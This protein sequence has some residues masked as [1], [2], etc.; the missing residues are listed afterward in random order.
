MRI[1]T[2]WKRIVAIVGLVAASLLALPAA[3]AATTPAGD[4]AAPGTAVCPTG[5]VC[6]Y[7]QPLPT[8]VILI[9]EG[10][11]AS[12]TPPIGVTRFTN[13]TRLDYCVIGNPSF[14]LGAGQDIVRPAPQ[15]VSRLFP[16]PGACLA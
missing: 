16:S 7:R 4:D 13:R 8:Q 1:T 12:F 11:S 14:E 2:T 3:S 10:R 5:F 6:L 15:P 9:P